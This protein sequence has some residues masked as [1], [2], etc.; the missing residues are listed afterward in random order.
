MKRST[1][2]LL[3]L[4]LLLAFISSI[5]RWPDKNALLMYDENSSKV[6][7]K[8]SWKKMKLIYIGQKLT[9]PLFASETTSNLLSPSSTLAQQSLA[10]GTWGHRSTNAALSLEAWW[11]RCGNLSGTTLPSPARPNSRIQRLSSL[12]SFTA[13]SHSSCMT[14]SS[15]RSMERTADLYEHWKTSNASISSST[16]LSASARNNP[17][18]HTLL[19]SCLHW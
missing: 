13:P 19:A 5:T 10:P 15:A 1:I 11:R 18:P 2:L 16:Q 17:W 12:C 6:G 14:P 7:L 8:A 9:P 4:I 3:A